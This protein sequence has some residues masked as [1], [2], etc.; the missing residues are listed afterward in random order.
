[1]VT[2]V[3]LTGVALTF[4]GCPVGTEE[5]YQRTTSHHLQAMYHSFHNTI[6]L[7]LWL[8]ILPPC[9]V[10]TRIAAENGPG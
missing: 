5:K 8:H 2:E 9:D 6:Y 7:N 3:E 4:V 10:M 1:M